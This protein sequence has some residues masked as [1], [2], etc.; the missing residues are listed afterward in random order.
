MNASKQKTLT[1]FKKRALEF[2]KK[3]IDA[4]EALSRTIYDW[5]FLMTLI[6]LEKTGSTG[7]VFVPLEI[8]KLNSTFKTRNRSRFL[9]YFH[10]RIWKLLFTSLSADEFQL[11]S[12][13]AY[14][15]TCINILRLLTEKKTAR[16]IYE[17]SLRS[18]LLKKR[19]LMKQK[20]IQ[21]VSGL[22]PDFDHCARFVAFQ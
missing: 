16:P 9:R 3:K 6:Q 11:N 8:L 2:Q 20:I 5:R 21:V 10:V 4:L 22:H 15:P 14:I 19:N 17:S 1:L 12:E 13:S 18:L 7:K